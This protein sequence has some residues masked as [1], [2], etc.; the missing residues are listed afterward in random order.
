MFSIA[1]SSTYIPK[2][3]EMILSACDGIV[4][5]L[6][7]IVVFECNKFDPD[8]SF[9]EFLNVL[10]VYDVLLNNKKLLNK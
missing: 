6:D 4:N 9:N 2:I 10:K 7:D 5:F 1:C 8:T 3:L